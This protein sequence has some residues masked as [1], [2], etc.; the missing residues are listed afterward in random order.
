MKGLFAGAVLLAMAGASFATWPAK[1][2]S[3]APFLAGAN[4][5]VEVRALLERSCQDCHSN[6]TRYPWYS[7]VA[8]VSWL[9]R[10]D[11]TRGRARLNFSDWGQYTFVRRLRFLSE[12]ANQ[13]ED[14]DMPLPV[15]TVIHRRARLSDAETQAIFHW[16]QAERLR[17]IAQAP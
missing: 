12:I 14:R 7:Y 15:Y 8:P 1:S 16:T 5:P 3:A 11:V 6:R 4:V 17:L 10:R 13:V 2:D 9:V